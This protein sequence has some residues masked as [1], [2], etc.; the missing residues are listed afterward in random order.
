MPPSSGHVEVVCT[1]R[2]TLDFGVGA[3]REAIVARPGGSAVYAAVGARVWNEH[4]GLLG[5]VGARFPTDWLETCRQ[6]GI[7]T[8][9]VRVVPD[10]HDQ[11][12]LVAAAPEEQPLDQPERLFAEAGLPLP[13][14]LAGWIPYAS[15]KE[16]RTRFSPLAVRPSEVPRSY[17]TAR[18]AHIAPCELVVQ[19][20]LPPTLR[21]SGLSYVTCDPHPRF[22][23]PEFEAD[24]RQV[25]F[26]LDAFLPG[27]AAVRAFFR[28]KPWAD[29]LWQCAE[30]LAAMGARAV[31]IK[32]GARGAL[33]F[34]PAKGRRWQVGGYAARV[35]E[36][37]GAGAAF[38][39]GFVA[40]LLATDDILEAALR[41]AVSASLVL[42]GNQPL[43][44]LAANPRLSE[45][46][47]EAL[48]GQVRSI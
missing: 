34:D 38:G 2:L 29:D 33:V 12:E 10:P 3:N 7:E 35:R 40:G 6:Q 41:G 47:L 13:V 28:G 5:R 17:L 45:A 42:E 36:R 14:E 32:S 39:G 15:R 26:G 27:E 11:L 31:V 16:E 25:V 19:T 44:A 37:V 22:M 43:Y 4:V 21:R 1:G 24:V 9:G 30:A 46:R 23:T 18:A 20:A 8:R 48:R